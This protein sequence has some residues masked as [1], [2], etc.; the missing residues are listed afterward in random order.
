MADQS[1]FR[2]VLD[3]LSRIGIYDVVLPFLLIFSIVFAILD[4]TKVFG[5][6][7]YDGK[8]YPKKNINAMIAFVIAFFVVASAQLVQVIT[9][10][11]SHVVILL[12]ASV[13]FL[14]MIGSFMKE[15]EDGVFLEDSWKTGFMV[16]MLIGIVLIFL[17]ALNWLMPF[18]EFMR[19]HWSDDYVAAVILLLVIYLVMRFITRSPGGTS[20]SKKDKEK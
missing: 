4:K 3:F 11:S 10:I 12:L 8:K 16:A 2:G 1:A 15:T 7:E 17:N 14:T 20:E 9:T 19:D 6:D 13:F 18:Y 5:A